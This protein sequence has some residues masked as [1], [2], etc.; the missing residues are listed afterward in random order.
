[1]RFPQKSA[2]D[3]GDL[4]LFTSSA[5]SFETRGSLLQAHARAATILVDELDTG[6]LQTT[7]DHIKRSSSWFVGSSL[8]LTHCYDANLSSFCELL[9]API[10]ETASGSTLAACHHVRIMHRITDSI[11]SVEKRLTFYSV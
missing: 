2:H 1:M 3:A 7:S 4:L 9:L 11:N 8:Q 6:G 5:S 10:Q